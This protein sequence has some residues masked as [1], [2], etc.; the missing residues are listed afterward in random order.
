MAEDSERDERTEEPTAR[1]LDQAR[2]QGQIPRSREF[3]TAALM[4][5]AAVSLLWLGHFMAAQFAEMM[6]KGF[7]LTREDLFRDTAIQE[8]FL[9]AVVDMLVIETPVF[10]ILFVVALAAPIGIGGWNFAAQSALPKFSRIDPL[11]GIKR[12]FS[13]YGVVELGKALLKFFLIAGVTYFLFR[14]Y[15]PALR[16]LGDEDTRQ[17]LGE[18]AGILGWVFLWL[19]LSLGL[20]AAID[21]P[22]QIWKHKRDLRMTKQEVRDEMKDIEGRPEVK[23]RIRALQMEL[24]RRRMMEEVP[25][26]DV[27]VTNP[28][29]YAV[30]LRYAQG[31]MRAPRVV[32]KGADLIAAQIRTIAQEAGV[33][34]LEAPPLARALFHAGTVGEEIPAGLYMAVAQ[35]LAWVYQLRAVQRHGG[36]EPVPPIDLPIPAELY[37]GEA[38]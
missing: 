36:E 6:R 38:D 10:L 14:H 19:C 17:A 9:T 5:A 25:K 31:E 30:A 7:R 13:L 21:A 24:A 22:Y 18:A 37:R 12:M 15:W 11:A 23:Q 35:V 29:H 3:N 8:R 26:A 16:A 1:R 27:I 34:R 4:L 20:I 2:E 28:T 32:A 33:P